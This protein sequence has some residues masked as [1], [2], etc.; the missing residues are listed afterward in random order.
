M[1]IKIFKIRSSSIASQS[2]HVYDYFQKLPSREISH[3]HIYV[4]NLTSVNNLNKWVNT[5]L[6]VREWMQE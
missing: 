1:I 3:I 5:I 2:L 4:T 6:N